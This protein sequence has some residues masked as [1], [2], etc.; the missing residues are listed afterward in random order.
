M[1]QFLRVKICGITQADQAVAIAQMG[2]D[3]LGFICVPTS[4]RY[5]APECIGLISAQLNDSGNSV[6]RIGVFADTALEHIIQTTQVGNLT[7]L[8]LHGSESPEFCGAVREALPHL[9]LIKA[10]KVKSPETLASVG[11]YQHL[12]DALLLDAYSPDLLGGTGIAWDWTMLQGIEFPVPWL[13]AGGLTPENIDTAIAILHPPGIDLSSGV[14]R[15]PG[16]KD[17]ERVQQL[18]TKIHPLQETAR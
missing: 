15:A 4:P 5:V 10:L 11:T 3:T 9:E 2:A 7:G 18:F 16:D 17:L 6:K 8:Q 13:L 1:G 12:V 14:E